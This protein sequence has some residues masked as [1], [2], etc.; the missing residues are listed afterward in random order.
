M[1]RSCSLRHANV[2]KADC[3]R[4]HSCLRMDLQ[5]YS[6]VF[7]VG[8]GVLQGGRGPWSGMSLHLRLRLYSLVPR[9]MHDSVRFL[10][11][12]GARAGQG[13]L[14]R[15]GGLEVTPM[16]DRLKQSRV[17]LQKGFIDFVVR[18]SRFLPPLFTHP[19]T[20]PTPPRVHAM[21]AARGYAHV[22]ARL[23]C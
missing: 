18:R 14:E 11:R 20:L 13:D 1:E 17:G 4:V 3:V 22:L 16:C 12:A 8:C 15:E 21:N 9:A 6:C 5:V 10:D 7:A 19:C 2:A 23:A